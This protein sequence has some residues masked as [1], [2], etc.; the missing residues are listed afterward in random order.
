MKKL[1]KFNLLVLLI[2]V[3]AGCTQ[4]TN[5]IIVDTPDGVTTIAERAAVKFKIEDGTIIYYTHDL[6][7]QKLRV[8][9]PT[10]IFLMD[11]KSRAMWAYVGMWMNIP[12][13]PSMASEEYFN[14]QSENGL[15]EQGFKK[16]GTMTVLGKLCDVYTGDN[17]S[18][19]V[20]MKIAI[21]NGITMWIEEAGKVTY[22]AL[23]VSLDIPDNFFE[24][25]TLEHSWIE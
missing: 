21:W 1:L 25:T 16:T 13:S 14:M 12:W 19:Y 10:G 6:A 9:I 4:N 7:N 23:A 8:D 5:K 15:T 11:Y 18:T 20:E 17:P 3:I 2:I 22:E 24:Q